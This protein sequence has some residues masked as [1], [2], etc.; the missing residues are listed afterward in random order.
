M[1]GLETVCSS[2]RSVLVAV[3]RLM[4]SGSS[5][6]AESRQQGNNQIDGVSD[7]LGEIRI[8]AELLA[9][10]DEDEGLNQLVE[11]SSHR[12]ALRGRKNP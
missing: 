5:S 8:G 1:R 2:G 11:V 3:G 6:R 4:T 9:E 12:V 7:R 10:A